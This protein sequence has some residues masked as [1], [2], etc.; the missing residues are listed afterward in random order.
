MFTSILLIIIRDGNPEINV[1][2]QLNDQE[3]VFSMLLDYWMGTWNQHLCPSAVYINGACENRAMPFL[4]S[5]ASHRTYHCNIFTNVHFVVVFIIRLA[6]SIYWT[7]QVPSVGQTAFIFNPFHL[8]T[9]N[10]DHDTEYS[11]SAKGTSD[12]KMDQIRGQELK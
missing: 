9:A 5:S 11:L 4:T 8:R 2:W 12:K 6:I 7:V 1:N 10:E 3:F